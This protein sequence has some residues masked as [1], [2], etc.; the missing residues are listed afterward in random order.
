M[1]CWNVPHLCSSAG[2]DLCNTLGEFPCSWDAGLEHGLPAPEGHTFR[3][4]S[5]QLW[6][7]SRLIGAQLISCCLH[8][9]QH[10]PS[11]VLQNK[12]R[13]ECKRGYIGDGIQ[14][15][16]EAVPPTDRCLV[17]NGQCHREAICTDLH[18][19]GERHGGHRWSRPGWRGVGAVLTFRG[20]ILQIRPWVYS[21]CNHPERSTTSPTC[22]RRRRV[23]QRGQSWPRSS[24]WQLRS[25]W[26]AT[27]AVGHALC[28][29][30]EAARA[31]R[32]FL[33][34]PAAFVTFPL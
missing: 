24:S 3:C 33:S 11:S 34:P 9:G 13:C 12:R 19:H 5:A 20:S 15:L 29:L 21:I 27:G 7:C 18:F 14:C 26:G 6:Q 22:R 31:A 4:G 17:S 1:Q 10:R 2:S 16:E 32:F 8:H 23:L 25:R 30:Q 28:P